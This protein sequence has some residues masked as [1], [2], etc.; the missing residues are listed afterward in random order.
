A[1]HGHREG[2]LRVGGVPHAGDEEHRQEDAAEDEDDEAVERDLTEQEGPVV[3]EDLAGE[4]LDDLADPGATVEVVGRRGDL[5]GLA[6]S[7]GAHR[8]SSNRSRS[9]KLGPTVSWKS[10]R[11][12]R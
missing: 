11:A 1:L 10:E 2:V 7:R 4:L 8:F 9:Q 6:R 5:R 12:T 3:G